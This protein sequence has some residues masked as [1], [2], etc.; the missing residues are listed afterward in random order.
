[1][2][3]I[4]RVISEM[5]KSQLHSYLLRTLENQRAVGLDSEKSIILEKITFCHSAAVT[6]FNISSYMMKKVLNEHKYGQI[7]YLLSQ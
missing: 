2:K 5:S 3:A 6:F 1:M 4:E 7:E